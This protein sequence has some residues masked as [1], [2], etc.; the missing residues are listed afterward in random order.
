MYEDDFTPDPNDKLFDELDDMVDFAKGSLARDSGNSE[1][2]FDVSIG[3]MAL[4]MEEV[5]ENVTI[6][7]WAGGIWIAE[8]KYHNINFICVA[9]THKPEL[10]DQILGESDEK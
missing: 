4:I 7:Q 5:P 2:K 1:K 3:L 10:W 6:D 9:G 8:A